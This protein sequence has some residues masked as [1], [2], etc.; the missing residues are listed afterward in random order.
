MSYFFEMLNG[1]GMLG[2]YSVI[3]FLIPI[4][5]G[6]IPKFLAQRFL[7]LSGSKIPSDIAFNDCWQKYHTN[8]SGFMGV[9][10]VF[11][12]GFIVNGNSLAHSLGKDFSAGNAAWIGA[13]VG[14]S[15][16]TFKMLFKHIYFNAY[17]KKFGKTTPT[18]LPENH[19]FRKA[20]DNWF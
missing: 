5:L 17:I 1:V 10:L 20:V 12:A 8:L 6:L 3:F 11:A 13:G 2:W 9:V 18:F 15:L 14:V 4:L 19:W 16:T 7:K